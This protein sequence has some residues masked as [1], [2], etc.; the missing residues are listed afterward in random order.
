MTMKNCA[1]PILLCLINLFLLASCKSFKDPEL[2][3]IE[4][5]SITSIGLKESD[6]SFDMTFFNPN[7]FR[8]KLKEAG[9]EAWMDG[10]DLGHFTV[11]TLIKIPA[12]SIFH[13]PIQLKM[14]MSHFIE[15][16]SA[17]FTDKQVSL[18]FDGMAR[19]GKG[20]IFI[21]YP[22]HYEGKQKLGELLK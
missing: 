2:K 16:L 3:K 14:D 1:S 22:I 5:V 19:V 21:N 9:G 12:R 6:L 7:N 18:K 17:A 13:L 8:L 11:D 20:I 15:N 4:K 10:N